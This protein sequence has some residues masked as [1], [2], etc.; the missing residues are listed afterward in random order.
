M[1][2]S[3]L[4]TTMIAGALIAGNAAAA[5]L[6]M[7]PAP[8]PAYAP[9][10]VYNWSG[11][12]VGLHGGYLWGDAELSGFA[13]G[14]PDFSMDSGFFGIQLGY[15]WQSG[16]W[17]FGAETDLSFANADGSGFYTTGEGIS[18]NLDWFGTVRGKVGY[19]FDRVLVYGTGGLAF[20]RIEA[21]ENFPAPDSGSVDKTKFGWTLGA[22][23]DWAFAQNWSAGLE[24]RHMD[25]GSVN[26]TPTYFGAGDID[27]T[28]DSVRLNLNYRF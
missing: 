17:V 26:F 10:A 28:T 16:A 25:F 5:D 9:V 1:R 3:I 20:G 4:T 19:A 18:A 2:F 7:R 13:P 12:N 11:V 14:V 27:V 23:I 15:Q 8:S 21:E 22:G 6:G 24:Y